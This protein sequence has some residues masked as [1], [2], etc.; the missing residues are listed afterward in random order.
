MLF[1]IPLNKTLLATVIPAVIVGAP[2]Y[3]NVESAIQQSPSESLKTP[4]AGANTN[5]IA[6]SLVTVKIPKKSDQK[7][8]VDFNQLARQNA[9]QG[10]LKF[11]QQHPKPA[12][13]TPS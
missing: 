11:L 1:D 3:A 5:N 12:A 9:K 4:K 7:L 2:T 13:S 8:D 10:T 6:A